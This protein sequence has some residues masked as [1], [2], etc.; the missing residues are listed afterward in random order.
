M[1]TQIVEVSGDERK[2]LQALDR[3]IQKERDAERALG[4]MGDAGASAGAGIEDALARIAR[5]NEKDMGKFLA[6][7]GR[8]GPEGKAAAD[9]LK[10]SFRADG[11]FGNAGVDKIIADIRKID[12]EAADAAEAVVVD[13]L[14]AAQPEF[15]SP[16]A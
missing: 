4:A 10:T 5:A 11:K 7:L 12:P 14:E 1:A 13:G 8:V 6:D 3:M 16:R 15:H 9:A 2:L